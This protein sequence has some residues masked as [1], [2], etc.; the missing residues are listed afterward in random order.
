M[1]NPESFIDEV[2]E[3][4]R[5]DKLFA[6]FRKYGWIAV[7]AIFAIVGA[8]AWNEWQKARATAS[9]QAFGDALLASLDGETPKARSAA[10]AAV[11]ATGDQHAVRLLLEASDPDADRAGTLTALATLVA[12]KTVPQAYRDLAVL[13]QVILSGKETPIADRRAALGPV[14]TP[15]RAF[16]TMAVEQLAY[17]SLEA[18]DRDAALTGLRSLIEDQ[19][20]PGGQRRRAQQMITALGGDAAGG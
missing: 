20:A 4:V 8:A 6:L 10:L 12:D 18:G 1:S 16:R 11:P 15:G 9:A 7:L 14:A 19:D 2:T 3:E 13:R 5:R 17:L